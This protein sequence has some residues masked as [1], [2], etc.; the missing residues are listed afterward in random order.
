MAQHN[1]AAYPNRDIRFVGSAR[2]RDDAPILELLCRLICVEQDASPLIAKGS[3]CPKM[4]NSRNC[5]L[6]GDLRSTV[7]HYSSWNAPFHARR[8]TGSPSRMPLELH[9]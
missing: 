4:P 8:A 9:G 5:S 6:F 3:E 1:P 7:L 2:K